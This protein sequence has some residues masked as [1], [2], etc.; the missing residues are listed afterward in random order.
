MPEANGSVACTGYE[1]S[2]ALFFLE[3]LGFVGAGEAD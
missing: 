3:D 1:P 2:Q